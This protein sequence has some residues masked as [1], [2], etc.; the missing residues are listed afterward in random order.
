MANLTEVP[1][2]LKANCKCCPNIE[3]ILNKSEVSLIHQL[4]KLIFMIENAITYKKLKMITLLSRNYLVK[5]IQYIKDDIWKSRKFP[6][7][8]LTDPNDPI[9]DT[10]FSPTGVQK[11]IL[12][13]ID[14]FEQMIINLRKKEDE[15]YL[16]CT[17]D[18]LP[19]LKRYI[20][21]NFKENN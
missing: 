1:I 14:N 9:L 7:I 11:S 2:V 8:G 21:D 3:Y 16:I 10:Q 15:N 20:I 18:S 19:N 13:E 5:M 6:D 12:E 4:E 17:L